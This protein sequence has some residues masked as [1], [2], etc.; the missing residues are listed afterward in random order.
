[1]GR[2]EK[3]EEMVHREEGTRATPCIRKKVQGLHCLEGRLLHHRPDHRLVVVDG[4]GLVDGV[5]GKKETAERR[6]RWKEGNGGK[7]E[8][9]QRISFFRV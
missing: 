8:F 9:Q 1:M 3:R 4:V 2:R 5:C 7:K 6:K